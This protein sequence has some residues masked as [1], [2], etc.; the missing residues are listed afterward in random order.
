MFLFTTPARVMPKADGIAAAVQAGAERSGTNFNYLLRT[1][2][3][4][5]AMNP[6]A[7]AGTSSA[8]GLF[9]FIEQTWLQMVKADGGKHGLNR[10][11]EAIE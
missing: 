2:Q 8:T 5:S 11:A 3:R 9:Q 7:K 10:Y 1:A 4:E 6:T